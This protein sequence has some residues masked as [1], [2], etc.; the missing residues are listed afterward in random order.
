MMTVAA[1]LGL[2]VIVVMA[3]VAVIRFL[4]WL[5]SSGI[6]A[7]ACFFIFLGILGLMYS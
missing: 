5:L 2:I 6:F 1:I 3:G 4:F 7:A